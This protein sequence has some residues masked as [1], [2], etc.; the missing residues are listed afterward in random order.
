MVAGISLQ[1]I[2]GMG[3][4]E[5][6]RLIWEDHLFLDLA[7]LRYTARA[8]NK[9]RRRDLPLPGFV[10]EILSKVPDKTGQLV[11]GYSAKE[12][13]KYSSIVRS[14]IKEWD[15]QYANLPCSDLRNTLITTG[16][17]QKGWNRSL[18]ERFV[19]HKGN[20]DSSGRE[21]REWDI[22]LDHYVTNDLGF[23]FQK[24]QEEIIP[25]IE[26][27]LAHSKG[28]EQNSTEIAQSD[29]ECTKVQKV[30]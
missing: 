17:T 21:V 7:K 15:S 23:L 8:K 4:T 20:I 27:N 10:V 13:W 19:G 16:H 29:A 1:L 6:L 12:Y 2:L 24:Y 22:R 18:L 14:W 3:E 28:P 25:K 26:E 11:K 5:V 9:F 30:A